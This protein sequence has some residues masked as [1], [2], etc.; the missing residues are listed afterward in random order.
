MDCNSLK[1]TGFVAVVSG[2]THRV[3]LSDFFLTSA[4][5]N[6]SGFGEAEPCK[7]KI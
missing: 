4:S 5:S 2:V 7:L 3:S 1:I 6:P